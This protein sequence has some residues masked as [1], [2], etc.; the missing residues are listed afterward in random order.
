MQKDMKLLGLKVKDRVTGF[1]GIVTTIAFDLYGCI[2]AVV[3]PAAVKE[4][5]SLE[6]SRWFDAKR[7]EVQSESPVMPVPTFENVP[8]PQ[9]KPARR[10][11]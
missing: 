10:D 11:W 5:K 7:L 2:Q 4:D 3:T 9:E 1:T 8:G 6:D